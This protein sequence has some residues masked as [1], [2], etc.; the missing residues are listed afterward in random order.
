MNRGIRIIAQSQNTAKPAEVGSA[1]DTRRQQLKRSLFQ[2]YLQ[3]D[4]RLNVR[5]LVGFGK[6]N[7]SGWQMVIGQAKRRHAARLNAKSTI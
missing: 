6:F 5:F 1:F 7:S 4:H 3:P 2:F